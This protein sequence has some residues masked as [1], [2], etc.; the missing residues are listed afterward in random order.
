MS[1]KFLNT[2]QIQGYV[3]LKVSRRN[4]NYSLDFKLN[5]VNLYLIGEISY[6]SLANEL[7]INNP[8]IITRLVK[9]FRKKELKNLNLKREETLQKCLRLLKIQE[10]KCII[11]NFHH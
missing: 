4:N 5:V 9:I 1:I 11:K 7:K 3:G 8:C 10:V 2:Y 6:Q